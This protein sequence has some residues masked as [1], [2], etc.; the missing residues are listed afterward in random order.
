MTAL[1]SSFRA[2]VMLVAT[3]LSIRSALAPVCFA[4]AF[5]NADFNSA[6]VKRQ[7]NDSSTVAGTR[8]P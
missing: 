3:S 5:F 7:S 2:S 8:R 1:P 4:P 6:A